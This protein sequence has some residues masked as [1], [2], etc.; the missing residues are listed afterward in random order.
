MRSLTSVHCYFSCGGGAGEHIC[1]QYISQQP[2][3]L[4]FRFLFAATSSC[5]KSSL[6]ESAANLLEALNVLFST[7]FNVLLFTFHHV[8]FCLN[9]DNFKSWKGAIKDRSVGRKWGKVWLDRKSYRQRC[10]GR[11]L[12]PRCRRTQLVE[13]ETGF[14]HS[15]S[16][17]NDNLKETFIRVNNNVGIWQES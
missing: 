5:K 12:W 13:S 16:W 3:H 10:L 8:L 2:A 6:H 15:S 11:N 9:K 4:T 7:L 17:C 14:S 1:A